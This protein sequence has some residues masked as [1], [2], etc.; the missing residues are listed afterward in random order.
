[1][2][3]L[4]LAP[5]LLFLAASATSR[6]ARLPL[7]YAVD[8]RGHVLHS[9]V[10]LRPSQRVVIHARAFA[11]F[12]R[13]EVVDVARRAIRYVRADRR[14]EAHFPFVAPWRRRAPRG[15][16]VAVAGRRPTT[17]RRIT[18]RPRRPRYDPQPIEVTV[19]ALRRLRYGITGGHQVA[20]ISIGGSE[21]GSGG[22]QSLASTGTDILALVVGG[23]LSI[24]IGVTVV[25]MSRERHE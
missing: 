2:V 9:G 20:G 4:V 3:V 24:A 23:I 1:M 6:P 15:S 14:G 11:P 18:T 17:T 8:A 25:R 22:G 7:I 19:P 16:S 5:G 13:V 12:A 21:S 10:T